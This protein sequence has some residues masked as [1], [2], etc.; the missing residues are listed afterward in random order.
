M[1]LKFN[2]PLCKVK[3]CDNLK[4]HEDNHFCHAC[5]E[6][7]GQY[8]ED[9]GLTKHLEPEWEHDYLMDF[10]VKNKR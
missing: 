6:D 7:W 10:C 5:R 9:L 3:E 8:C 1:I 4:A 2:S